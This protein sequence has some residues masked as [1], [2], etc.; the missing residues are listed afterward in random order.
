[1]SHLSHSPELGQELE[2]KWN[3]PKPQDLQVQSHLPS[4]SD[5]ELP[6]PLAGRVK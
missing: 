6:I 4:P 2:E 5:L 3:Y 1:M